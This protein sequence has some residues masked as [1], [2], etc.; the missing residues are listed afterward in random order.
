MSRIR[1]ILPQFVVLVIYLKL[2]IMPLVKATRFSAMEFSVFHGINLKNENMRRSSDVPTFEGLLSGVS[3]DELKP[4]PLKCHC[5]N[6]P[7]IE[8]HEDS[9][10]VVCSNNNCENCLFGIVGSYQDAIFQWNSSKDVDFDPSINKIHPLAWFNHEY[11]STEY[12][13]RQIERVESQLSKIEKLPVS[14][15]ESR[16]INLIRGWNNFS[17]VVAYRL[18]NKKKVESISPESTFERAVLSKAKHRS[19]S[20][21]LKSVVKENLPLDWDLSDASGPMSEYKNSIQLI[22]NAYYWFVEGHMV[23]VKRCHHTNWIIPS[24]IVYIKNEGTTPGYQVRIDLRS[25]GIP[26][27]SKMY[28]EKDIYISLQQALLDLISRLRDIKHIRKLGDLIERSKL[29]GG[30]RICLEDV[31]SI[32]AIESLHDSNHR[33]EITFSA[34]ND[35]SGA[36]FQYSIG[37]K[38]TL[39]YSAYVRAINELTRVY[40]LHTKFSCD[41]AYVFGAKVPFMELDSKTQIKSSEC[42][43]EHFGL[44]ISDVAH[45]MSKLNPNLYIGYL[46]ASSLRQDSEPA[47]GDHP[48]QVVSNKNKRGLIS[49]FVKKHD[50]LMNTE[51]VCIDSIVDSNFDE[52][53]YQPHQVKFKEAKP[54]MGLLLSKRAVEM[55]ASLNP[56]RNERYSNIVMLSPEELVAKVQ[57]IYIEEMQNGQVLNGMKTEFIE[58]DGNIVIYCDG[59]RTEAKANLSEW[60]DSQKAA[61]TQALVMAHSLL[62]IDRLFR[63]KKA[64]GKK[65][66]RRYDA[67]SIPDNQINLNNVRFLAA[68]GSKNGIRNVTI[69]KSGF[70]RYNLKARQKENQINHSFKRPTDFYGFKAIIEEIYQEFVPFNKDEEDLL[71]HSYEINYRK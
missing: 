49:G 12:L 70:I 55:I 14:N 7:K 71:L 43:A 19:S 3:I 53:V 23:R 46:P 5:G 11:D 66:S 30:D 20:A 60:H 41:K 22:G 8:K 27:Y 37:G 4:N 42:I 44:S 26:Y 16:L 50:L 36:R 10:D 25:I 56:N 59:I 47:L 54:S 62:K 63:K 48:M 18:D 57:R 9:Y 6:Y 34:P 2:L 51:C 33:V 24:Y 38:T 61:C 31:K 68:R 64:D 35:K 21:G 40:L 29:K 17:S 67:L 45:H 69:N 1:N 28:N 58:I 65:L 13:K 32:R 39:T 15:K 52:Y